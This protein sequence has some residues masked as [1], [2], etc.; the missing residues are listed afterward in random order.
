MDTFSCCVAFGPLGIYLLLL[1][2]VNSSRRPLVV[3]GT[4][5][6]LA[7][8]LAVAGLVIVG[9]MQLFMPQEAATR[10][11][12]LVWPLLI[13][14]YV[15]ALTLVLMLSRP[16][17]VVYNCSLDQLR[18]LLTV[19]AQQLDR[20]S[21]WAGEAL[22]MP[23]LQVHLQLEHFPTMHNLSLLATGD[24]Q[25]VSGWRRLETA[26]RQ[27]VRTSPVAAR[28]HGFWLIVGGLTILLALAFCVVDDPQTIAQG[29]A[30]ILN[31]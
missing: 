17:I 29:L 9:P 28:T 25:S 11:G 18:P 20:D 6:T 5:E 14:F 22:S 16:R 19:T 10:F 4:R 3:S 13:L 23:Q 2:V 26:L 24:E 15:L 12:N 30:H 27:A 8:A 21:T 1:G 31:P 7:L